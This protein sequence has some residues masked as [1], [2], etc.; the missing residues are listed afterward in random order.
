ML[1]GYVTFSRPNIGVWVI[2]WD[3]YSVRSLRFVPAIA[4]HRFA[5]D[6]TLEI[7]LRV[8]KWVILGV[9]PG[10]CLHGFVPDGWI[11]SHLGAGQ[12]WSVPAAV[13]LG[14]PLYS[15]ATGVMTKPA[16]VVDEKVVS[17]SS[18]PE[19]DE[20]KRWLVS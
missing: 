5:R 15:N 8:W 17:C 18:I 19:K 3:P 10:A 16:V 6:E 14:I 13:L 12:W 11:E 1:S 4:R 20:I 7:F 9:G 2:S